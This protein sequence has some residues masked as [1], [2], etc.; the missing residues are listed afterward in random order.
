MSYKAITPASSPFRCL[1]WKMMV[2]VQS[3]ASGQ[4]AVPISGKKLLKRCPLAQGYI[5]LGKT[6]SVRLW[7]GSS[8]TSSRYRVEG[9]QVTGGLLD[10][11]PGAIVPAPGLLWPGTGVAR[12]QSG[13]ARGLKNELRPASWPTFWPPGLVNF[14]PA[15]INVPRTYR[16]SSLHGLMKHIDPAPMVEWRRWSWWSEPPNVYS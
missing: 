11:G 1:S 5:L 3:H 6:C 15:Q 14:H 13:L 8:C 7:W 4:G 9:K 12:D 2:P 16:Q 10:T